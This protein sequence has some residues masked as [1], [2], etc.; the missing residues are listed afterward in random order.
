MPLI[1][2]IQEQRLQ[3][4]R[5]E[6]QAR[7]GFLSF[8]TVIVL[9]AGSY[10]LLAFQADRLRQEESKLRAQLQKIAPLRKEIEASEL[11]FHE[12]EPR[13][14]I[15][16]KAREVSDKWTRILAHLAVN[17]P[18][19]TWMTAIRS[20]AADPEKP[21]A[22]SFIGIGGHQ[23]GVSEFIL[24]LQ[25]QTDLENVNLKYTQEKPMTDTVGIEFEVNADLAGSA[26]KK[27]KGDKEAKQS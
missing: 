17:T 23:E 8:A 19:T 16:V 27:P 10:G 24:R 2:L 20:T 14:Q 5:T 7:A 21:I 11:A 22:I 13:E 15:L 9:G 26:E 25:N 12:L 3:V 4:K 18:Q 6:R 1:N